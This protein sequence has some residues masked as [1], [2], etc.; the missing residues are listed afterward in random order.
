MTRFDNPASPGVD[1]EPKRNDESGRDWPA[2][3]VVG[4]LLWLSTMTRP[5]ITKNAV[6]AVAR[7]AH[8]PTGRFSQAIMKILSYLNGTKSFGI[9]YVRESGL[10]LEVYADA[11]YVDKANDKCSVT[12]IVVT[13]GGTVVALSHANKT[14]H[15]VS[16]STSETEYV[17]AGGRGQDSSVCAC[18]SVF[19]CAQD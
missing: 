13:V 7:Y 1:L 18:R 14:Q 2:G 11:D 16:L 8:T 6:R 17:A 19:P 4:S 15:V 10:G 5:D 3:E 12:G 9:T